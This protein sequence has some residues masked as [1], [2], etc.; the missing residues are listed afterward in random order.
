MR[1]KHPKLY[2]TDADGR[3]AFVVDLGCNLALGL[4]EAPPVEHHEDISP[5]CAHRLDIGPVDPS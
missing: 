5:S 2:S 1:T 3:W 4:V